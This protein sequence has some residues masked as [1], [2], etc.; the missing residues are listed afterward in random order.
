MYCSH[1]YPFH[2]CEWC[3]LKKC[4]CV[5]IQ[6]AAA[7]E[8]IVSAAKGVDILTEPAGD[9][10]SERLTLNEGFLVDETWAVRG[11]Q[12]LQLEDGRGWV[13]ESL[14]GVGTL[15]QRNELGGDEI[16]VLASAVQRTILEG[17]DIEPYKNLLI[18]RFLRC[19]PVHDAGMRYFVFVA[20][21]A[22]LAGVEGFW[23]SFLKDAAGVD[24]VEAVFPGG[25]IHGSFSV[26]GGEVA[27]QRFG[28]IFNKNE[29]SPDD[30]LG[31]LGIP[32][33]KHHVPSILL[34]GGLRDKQDRYDWFVGEAV[35][36]VV[37]GTG[38]AYGV[39]EVD[40]DNVKLEA[41]G[42]QSQLVDF[43]TGEGVDGVGRSIKVFSRKWA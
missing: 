15:C 1:A 2:V 33:T 30:F 9:E 31:L 12:Y 42:W 19:H 32:S 35:V 4:K 17:V 8:W 21:E 28:A 40:E 23:T 34:H 13:P 7:Q 16:N 36:L 11:T 14:H 43:S 38:I 26:C 22:L 10:T 29:I 37:E 24:A 18:H 6:E 25:L 5:E 20:L 27:E 39:V 41:E 3:V